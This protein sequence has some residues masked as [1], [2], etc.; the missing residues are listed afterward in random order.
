MCS[1][2]M[3]AASLPRELCRVGG[4]SAKDE[5]IHSLILGFS[6]LA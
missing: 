3:L 5:P 6:I 1:L 2:Y 4:S